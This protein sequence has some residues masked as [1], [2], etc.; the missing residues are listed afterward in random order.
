LI[1]VITACSKSVEYEKVENFDDCYIF[2]DHTYLYI[3]H[4][5]NWYNAKNAC[6]SQK[7]HLLIINSEQ[8]ND[9]IKQIIGDNTWLGL[10]DV[11][12]EGFWKWIDNSVLTWS[13]WAEGEPNNSGIENYAIYYN[14]KNYSWN[15]APRRN[16][17][18][19]ICEIDRK[20][21]SED[22]LKN[23]ITGITNSILKYQ[24]D[25]HVNLYKDIPD[26]YNYNG[27]TYIY[28]DKKTRWYISKLASENS[29]GHLLV[30]DNEAENN[31]I[32]KILDT[33][34]W[35]GLTDEVNEGIWKWVNGEALI[36]SDWME[37]Q[38][39]NT[40]NLEH[41]AYYNLNAEYYNWN[42]RDDIAD[43]KFICEYDFEITETE[44]LVNYKNDLI[45]NVDIYIEEFTDSIDK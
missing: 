41:Y 39:D 4:K 2:N 17:Y 24:E 25:N 26:C 23:I 43:Y 11:E 3:K 10:S 18:Y 8:E 1:F 15:D 27:H 13:D 21:D 31:Y 40:A 37:R 28:V 5:I 44:V 38:P 32:K 6:E 19:F 29:G 42:D 34:T 30:I 45:M 22:Q 16:E 20:I 9:F 33:S 12:N 36:F 35:I 14:E 7:A